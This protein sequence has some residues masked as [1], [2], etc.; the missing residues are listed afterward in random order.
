MEI[1]SFCP[2]YVYNA[3]GSSVY[4]GA[5]PEKNSAF[6]SVYKGSSFYTL[7]QKDKPNKMIC[8]YFSPA[9]FL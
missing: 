4:T 7:T 8:T 2:V 3:C 1:M 9:W 6:L 5:F